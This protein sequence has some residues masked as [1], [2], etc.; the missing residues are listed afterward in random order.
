MPEPIMRTG[1]IAP[2]K[3]NDEFKKALNKFP[4][5]KKQLEEIKFPKTKKQEKKE[6]PKDL[7]ETLDKVWNGLEKYGLP[8]EEIQQLKN[9]R[10]KD[11]KDLLE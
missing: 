8:K 10:N 3:N 1:Y 4:R 7:N 9:R 11:I 5:V 2:A 6:M